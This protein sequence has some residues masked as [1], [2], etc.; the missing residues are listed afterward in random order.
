MSLLLILQHHSQFF[1]ALLLLSALFGQQFAYG[2]GADKQGS[3]FELMAQYAVFGQNFDTFLRNS[4]EFGCGMS[5]EAIRHSVG[6]IAAG[7]LA[8][9][10][11]LSSQFSGYFHS[12]LRSNRRVSAIASA[13][14][15]P[16]AQ[17]LIAAYPHSRAAVAN[18][19]KVGF[20]PTTTGESGKWKPSFPGSADCN[21]IQ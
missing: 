5:I 1:A 19:T 18:A 16:S 10:C 15:L 4:N 13:R 21:S 7:P 9:S 2:F 8:L 20:P 11:N 3:T 6:N 12:G 17:Q 14:F